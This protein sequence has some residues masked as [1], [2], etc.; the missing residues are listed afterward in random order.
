MKLQRASIEALRKKGVGEV[1]FRAGIK[2][3]GARMAAIYRRAGAEYSGEM[4]RLPL[5]AA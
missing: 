3:D 4:Y 1:C 2:G 5:K